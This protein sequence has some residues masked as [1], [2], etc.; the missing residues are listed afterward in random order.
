MTSHTLDTTP[1]VILDGR[2]MSVA[3]VV[4]LAEGRHTATAAADALKRV[5]R[6][7]ETARALTAAGTLYGRSTGVG[8]NRSII[9][10]AGDE[11]L[12][13]GGDTHGMRLLRSHAGSIGA[14]LPA[15]QVRA[16]LA[17]RLNQILA[18]GAGVKP[19]IVAAIEAALAS[20]ATPLVHEFGAVGTG[21][22]GA[23]AQ[24]GLAL[25]GEHPWE[26]GR[27]PAP[28]VLDTND[29]LALISSNALTLGQAALALDRLRL[30]LR[31]AQVVA[32]LGL[33]AVDG[34]LEAYAHPVHEARPHEGT[35][36][37][38]AE[39]R[40][41][42]DVQGPGPSGPYG[43]RVRIQD[44]FAFRCLPQVH[45]PALDSAD[46]L[47]RVLA[48]DL[49]AAAENP[50]IRE[51]THTAWHHGNFFAGHLAL[52]LDQFRLS[53]LQVAQ[54]STARLGALTEPSMTGLQPFLGDAEAPGSS[55]VMIL[56]YAAAAA[57]AELRTAAAPVTL[58]HTSLSRGVEEQSSF[59]SQAARLALR[60]GESLRQ[61]L[62]CELVT[63]VRALRQRKAVP[64]GPAGEA[65]EVAARVLDPRMA[66]RPLT[67]DV[68]VAGGLMERLAA[69]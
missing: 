30:L 27:A 60:A 16:M 32:A 67:A 65:F 21:D 19:A 42:L 49:N 63:A 28:I 43:A 39:I 11:G 13:D 15:P 50:L 4:R 64:G 53:V 34:S 69:F 29:A 7:W 1:A 66:D 52:A 41:L 14:P 8:A 35:V 10:E 36:A 23:L 48:V 12:S 56:E 57:L 26:G 2:D 37:A 22:L 45:G 38:A 33:H 44:P 24:T 25:A 62:A 3:D 61:V 51:D 46:A 9:V 18:G 47:E 68:A 31:A 6:S 20:G 59:A 40:R 54:L 17:V 58:G 5:H 55:G